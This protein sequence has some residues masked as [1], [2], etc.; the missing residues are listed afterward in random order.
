M[1]NYANLCMLLNGKENGEELG[2]MEGGKTITRVYC[3]R[4]KI[5]SIKRKEKK[6]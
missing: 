2:G 4:K 5:V 6:L 3:V 1:Q